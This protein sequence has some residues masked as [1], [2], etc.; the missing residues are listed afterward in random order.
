MGDFQRHFQHRQGGDVGRVCVDDAVHVRAGA[1][2]PAVESVGRVR[3]AV[4][5]QHFQVFV[6]QQQVARGDFVETQA[7]LL[8]VVGARLWA[9]GGDLPGQPR[10]VTVL[11][12]N[13]AGQRQLLSVS[14]RII[15][16]GALHLRKRLLD[17]LLF[18]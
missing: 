18:R 4:A 17:E 7:Q 3:H 15:R 16:Q 12:Q 10:V 9:T 13:A 1:V 14:P 11:E 2:D 8:G 5:F 6:D